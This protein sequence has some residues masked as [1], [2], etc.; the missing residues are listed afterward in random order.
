MPQVSTA[1]E[2]RPKPVAAALVAHCPLCAPSHDEAPPPRELLGDNEVN[3]N[4]CTIWCHFAALN[5]RFM[6][7]VKTLKGIWVLLAC[8]M[9]KRRFNRSR[10]PAFKRRAW[11]QNRCDFKCHAGG[12]AFHLRTM[13]LSAQVWADLAVDASYG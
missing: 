11:A 1:I 4:R 3:V 9:Q 2:L 12:L 8:K 5:S 6:S 13:R 7:A 10:L